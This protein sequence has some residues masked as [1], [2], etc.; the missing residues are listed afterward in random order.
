MNYM[1][2][3]LGTGNKGKIQEIR[4]ALAGSDVTI[5]TP[6]DLG[7]QTKPDETGTTYQENAIQKARF[8]FDWAHHPTL[9]DDSGIVVDA[10]QN[11]LGIHTRR[12]GKGPDA[13]DSDWIEF[14]LER[15]RS[16]TN[17]RAHFTCVLAYIDEA[18][19]LHLFEGNCSGVITNELETDFLPGLP[20]SACFKPDGYDKVFSALSI[21]EKNQIS[22]R[23]RA[24]QLFVS[25]VDDGQ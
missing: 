21:E 5:V 14:F 6:N 8:Y 4:D 3:L 24:L 22:H 25:F 11:E 19:T 2:L 12:W 23:G 1:N 20:I 7:I 15:M 13:T 16:E 18:G 17:R 10:L 9:A